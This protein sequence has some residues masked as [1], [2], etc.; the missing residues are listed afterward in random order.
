M[1]KNKFSIN[2]NQFLKYL[3][4][5]GAGILFLFKTP[6]KSFFKNKNIPIKITI[7]PEAVKK[8]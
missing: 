2:R 8:G 7:N 6:V 4:I 1:I 3:G 5:I